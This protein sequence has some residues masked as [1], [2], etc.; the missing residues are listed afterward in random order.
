M[1]TE[2]EFPKKKVVCC[3]TCGSK[4]VEYQ[5]GF[6]TGLASCLQKLIEAG[7]Q[8][9]IADIGLTKSQYTNITKMRHWG[10]IIPIKNEE[11][12]KKRGAW[13]V[14][15]RGY[16]FYNNEIDIP[17]FVIT[18]KGKLIRSEGPI[19]SIEQALPG[20]KHYKHYANQKAGQL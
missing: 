6:N 14:T 7:G 5:F 17:M 15:G 1:Q 3:P 10:L 19:I 20:W 11:S 2:F 16:D 8:A 18:I 13:K 12:L 4:N 9:N